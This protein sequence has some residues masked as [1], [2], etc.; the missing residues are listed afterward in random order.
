R[1]RAHLFDA[2][3]RLTVSDCSADCQ[4][5]ETVYRHYRRT[6]GQLEVISRNRET[7]NQ[8]GGATERHQ[9]G[10]L[11]TSSFQGKAKAS[12]TP[13]FCYQI[14][15]LTFSGQQVSIFIRKRNQ[16]KS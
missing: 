13:A 2:L 12:L 11:L 15:M 5:R 9:S 8:T 16:G 4:R 6:S 14:Q 10:A 3:L 1:D 7:A